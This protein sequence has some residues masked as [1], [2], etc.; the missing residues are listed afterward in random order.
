MKR[1]LDIAAI[2]AA[3]IVVLWSAVTCTENI[4]LTQQRDKYRNDTE[5]LCGQIEHYKTSDSLNAARVRSL[6]LSLEE[7][8]RFRA[9]DAQ[10]IKSL[11]QRN[12]DLQ[13]V[14]D[15]QMQTIIEM[16]GAPRDTI[17]I[18]DSVPVK[19]K[20]VECGDPWYDFR[21]ILTDTDFS[22]RLETRDSLIISESVEHKRFLNFLWKTRKVK[23]RQIDAVSRNPHSQI[24]DIVFVVIE[25]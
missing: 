10:V 5:V 2:V 14:N 23:N 15:M 6:E 12:R 1:V 18:R 7:F 25:D 8:E 11:K 3:I 21:G 4:E 9:Q 22:G 24:K 17:I 20:A 13:S 19:A 16:Q